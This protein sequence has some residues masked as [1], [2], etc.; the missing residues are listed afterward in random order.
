M[1]FNIT[2]PESKQ[3]LDKFLS[4]KLKDKTRSQ[5]KKMIKNGL[6]LIN[7]SPAKVHQF[8]KTKDQITILK[9]IETKAETTIT[10]KEKIKI[11]PKI[12]FENNDFLIID[13]PIGILVHPTDAGETG[14]LVD[15]LY[16][17]YPELETVGEYQNR[18]GI[19]HRLDKDVSGVMMVAKNDQAYY[20]LKNQFK[21][22]EV[23]KL[24]LA[25]VYGRANDDPGEINLPIGRNKDGQFV[26]HPR[27]GKEKFL[28]N[29]RVAKTKYKVLEYIKDYTLLEI[30]ILTGRTHQIRIH[31]SAVG[32]PILG[33]QV[34]KPRKKFLHFLSR[35]IKVVNPGRIFLHSHKLGFNDLNNN[36]V[37]FESAL[38]KTLTDFLND[39]KTK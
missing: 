28:A 2:E 16:Q 14:T 26:A 34:Y 27:Q 9:D 15:W 31:L 32:H 7:N 37:E 36:W 20:H 5:I 6:V 24:Y 22:R 23:K 39:Q 30:Q 3:R 1:N 18:G 10:E 29:D 33:D 12:I 25:L 35:R 21:E 13:K 19:I 38:P 11:D 8:L 4:L 17:K